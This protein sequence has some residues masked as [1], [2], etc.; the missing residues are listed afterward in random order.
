M[1]IT[2]P[3]IVRLARKS[4]IKSLSDDCYDTIRSIIHKRIQEISLVTIIVNSEH[5]TKTLMVEDLPTFG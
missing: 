3:A 2:K 5:Q 1:N 4:G